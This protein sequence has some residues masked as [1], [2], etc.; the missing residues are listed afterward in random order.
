MKQIRHRY[1]TLLILLMGGMTQTSIVASYCK[2]LPAIPQ[3]DY[4][5]IS[6]PMAATLVLEHSEI[7]CPSSPI[8]LLNRYRRSNSHISQLSLHAITHN[9]MNNWKNILSKSLELVHFIVINFP[10]E[11]ISYPFNAFW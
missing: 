4:A 9:C 6:M 8:T 7:N 10:S 1:L 11:K 5:T 3:S 2:P